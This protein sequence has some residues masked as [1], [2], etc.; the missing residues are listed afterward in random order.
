[1][2]SKVIKILLGLVLF[3]IILYVYPIGKLALTD[4]QVTK[5]LLADEYYVKISSDDYD[6]DVFRDYME[7]RGWKENEDKRMGGMYAF[8]K[9]GETKEIIN[10]QVKTIFVDGKLNF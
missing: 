8:E 2:K 5:S 3:A 7:S 10:T 6:F 1:M 9:N 4:T